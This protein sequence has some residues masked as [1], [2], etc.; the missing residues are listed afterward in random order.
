MSRKVRLDNKFVRCPNSQLLGF[1]T[2]R[3][4]NG[5]WCQWS[6]DTSIGAASH[7]GVVLGRI[8]E[9][10]DLDVDVLEDCR[11]WI[12]VET[13]SNDCTSWMERWVKPENV[14]ALLPMP[15]HITRLVNRNPNK[16]LEELRKQWA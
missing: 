4:K 8:A 5:L 1:S 12:V 16:A 11:N 14:L 15:K 9:L 6:D 3:S 2:S 7:C 10:Y 13:L